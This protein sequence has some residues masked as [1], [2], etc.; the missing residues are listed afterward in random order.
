[1]TGLREKMGLARGPIGLVVFFTM[2][3]ILHGLTRALLVL[4]VSLI[5][6]CFLGNKIRSDPKLDKIRRVLGVKPLCGQALVTVSDKEP[7]SPSLGD[8]VISKLV[9]RVSPRP[10]H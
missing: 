3:V 9:D 2:D 8:A 4:F 10:P 6:A 5:F 1:M 7:A